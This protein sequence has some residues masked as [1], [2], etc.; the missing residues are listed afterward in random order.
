MDNSYKLSADSLFHC[1]GHFNILCRPEKEMIEASGRTATEIN[2]M[3]ARPGSKFFS[4][5]VAEV[6]ENILANAV[7]TETAD[8]K[9]IVHALFEEPVGLTGVVSENELTDTMRTGIREE[10]RGPYAVRTVPSDT[11]YPTRE[12]HLILDATNGCVI[13]VF[14]GC[15]APAFPCQGWSASQ[16]WST[17]YFIRLT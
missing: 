12:A 10:M 8:G 6:V 3:L 14:P 7:K 9:T 2:A 17:H 1:L 16:F 15:Y 5:S 11:M 4:D 13:T